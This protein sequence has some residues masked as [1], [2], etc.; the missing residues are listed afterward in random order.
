MSH[1]F[2]VQE[3][4][5]FKVDGRSLHGTLIIHSTT[6][7]DIGTNSKG[8]WLVLGT[9]WEGEKTETGVSIRRTVGFCTNV[10]A[11][12]STSRV[13]PECSKVGWLLEH[14]AHHC[15]PQLLKKGS[16]VSAA[17]LIWTRLAIALSCRQWCQFCTLTAGLMCHLAMRRSLLEWVIW[18][19][20][21]G[22]LSRPVCPSVVKGNYWWFLILGSA[23]SWWQY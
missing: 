4:F 10:K 8:D 18:A 22:R 13:G 17:P 20:D 5:G 3:I 14:R 15:P 23:E 2:D 12:S 11:R 21:S 16:T 7:A 9:G 6:V 19:K 1:L